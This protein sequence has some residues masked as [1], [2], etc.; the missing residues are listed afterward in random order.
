MAQ[1]ELDPVRR[2][3]PSRVTARL[4]SERERLAGAVGAPASQ[5]SERL[6]QLDEE[7]DMERLLEPTRP[8]SCSVW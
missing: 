7:W 8:R 4:D 2:H 6:R 1:E 5:V 3:S